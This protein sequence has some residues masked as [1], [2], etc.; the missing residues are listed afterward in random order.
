MQVLVSGADGFIGR[1][2]SRELSQRGV[3][4]RR[5]VRAISSDA[6]AIAVGDIGPDTDWS[7]AL[8]GCDYVLHLAG[9]AHRVD[10][11]PAAAF[12]TFR[13]V[14]VFG[15]VR[16]FLQAA[17][18][19]VRRFVF[20]SS[21]GVNGNRSLR[22]F[23]EDD[24][25]CPQEPYAVSKLEA[26]QELAILAQRT[27]VELVIVRPPLVY[28]PDA[29]GNFGRLARLAAMPLPLPFA[30][31]DNRRSMVGIQNL[32]DFL[33]L[34]LSHPAAGSQTFLVADG[35]D[36]SVAELIRLMRRSCG[37]SAGLFPLPRNLIGFLAACAGKKALWEKFSCDV[38]VDISRARDLLG[39]APVLSLED[40]IRQA[41]RPETSA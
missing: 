33:V 21:I 28:G 11:P 9:R 26:E 7:A 22:P 37:Q 6:Q 25:A 3:T 1:A 20:V 31:I 8:Q 4:V 19:G 35:D 29:P 18:A 12:A 10:D 13:R 24:S 5:C 27:G 40:G 2:V 14:N 32:V 36:V 16:L 15:S 34:C 41:M 39:W 30:S 23:K 38:Q 17:N